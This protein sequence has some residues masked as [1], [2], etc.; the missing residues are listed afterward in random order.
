MTKKNIIIAGIGAVG[1]FFGGKLAAHYAE[2]PKADIFFLARGENEKKIRQDGLRLETTRGNL[3]ARPAGISSAPADFPVADLIVLCTKS[4]DLEQSIAQ[5]MPCIGPQTI[6]LPLLNGVDNR[7]RILK[8]LPENEVWDGCVFIVSRLAEP[9]LIRETGNISKLLFGHPKGGTAEQLSWAEEL[10]R[11]AGIDAYLSDH[12]LQDIW[13]KFS[14]ISPVATLTSYLDTSIG[15]ILRSPKE[16]DLQQTLMKE[17]QSVAAAKGI[18]LPADIVEKN[19]QLMATVPDESTSSMH[20]DY[21]NSK[22]TEVE[23]LTGYV[24]K[25]GHELQ[26]PTPTYEKMYKTLLEKKDRNVT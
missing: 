2:A 8:L 1:G 9:G 21:L 18:A 24:V 16:L 17:L 20:T 12:I 4:Y 3:L 22:N 7:E 14:F 10:F 11:Q 26:V 13:G 23:S 25:Q 6:L 15:H 19:I 5:L